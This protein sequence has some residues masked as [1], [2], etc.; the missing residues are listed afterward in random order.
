MVI[1]QLKSSNRRHTISSLL[2]NSCTQFLFVFLLKIYSTLKSIQNF[3]ATPDTP[4]LLFITQQFHKLTRKSQENWKTTQHWLSISEFNKKNLKKIGK[5]TQQWLSSPLHFNSSSSTIRNCVSH[6][7][8][9]PFFV[10]RYRGGCR[11]D[12]SF[13]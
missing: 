2:R 6:S 13:L 1:Q 7:L 10:T 9:T 5:T 4:F 11:L 3:E 12:Y 8:S